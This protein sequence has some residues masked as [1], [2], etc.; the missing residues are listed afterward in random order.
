MRP[1]D[2]THEKHTEPSKKHKTPREVVYFSIGI[3]A[4]MVAVR[5]ADGNPIPELQGR[6]EHVRKAILA[7]ADELTIFEGWPDG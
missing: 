5:D 6:Y 4:G 3:A 1:A 7:A 2:D